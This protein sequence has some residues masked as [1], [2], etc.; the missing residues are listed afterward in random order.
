MLRRKS[1]D[2]YGGELPSKLRIARRDRPPY[3][4]GVRQPT[5]AKV[6]VVIVGGGP[7][8][9]MLA[10]FLDYH[11]I[12]CTILNDAPC[13]YE[14]PRGSTHN[15]RTME[16]YRRLG[17]ADTIRELGLPA[18]HPT[19]V[20]Y[21]TRYSA[22]ELARIPMPSADAKRQA[23]AHAPV[24]GQFPEPLHRANQMYVE[25][26]LFDRARSRPGIAVRYGWR[27]TGLRQD[28]DRVI[29]SAE[30]TRDG[31]TRSW[32]ARYAVG[33]DGG[34]S[35]VRAA[36]GARYS[37]SGPIDQE[38]L[39]R[40]A[41]AVYLRIPE[42]YPRYLA[43]RR[44]WGYWAV[45]HELIINLISLN[46]S[47]EFFLLTSS[48]DPDNADPEQVGD[49]VRRAVGSPVGVRVLDRRSWTPGLAL[50][51]DRFAD[52]RILLAGD[53]A[54]LFTPTGG[55]G[56]NT[57]VDDAA[58]LSWKIAARLAG[59]GGGELLPS[60]ELER[61]PIAERNTAAARTLNLNLGDINPTDV[62]EDGCREGQEQRARTGRLLG[63]YA[64]QFASVGVQLGARYD[65]SPVIARDGADPPPDS[66][67]AYTPSSVPGGRAPHAWIGD[68]RERGDSLYDRLGPGFTLLRLGP[69]PPDGGAFAAAT[70]AA[71]VP[72]AVLPVPDPAVRDLY[73]RDLALIRPDQH[74][75]WRGNRPPDD[76]GELLA[77]VTGGGRAVY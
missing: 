4:R 19:D 15:A 3:S 29:V 8:G 77:R 7:V 63:A 17:L 59:W 36:I 12:P 53:A 40:R 22:F 23:V 74:V 64:E 39:G 1:N 46:G 41:S 24:T 69:R 37:G 28:D 42:L 54:H 49:L 30:H 9:L 52:R 65:R 48:V 38:V 47:D 72:L 43:R 33:C 26:V 73:E 45:N 35:V 13:P 50:V 57:G 5:P 44:A 66:P 34:R 11:G 6:P 16:H 27:V 2:G 62:L 55:F 58:N 60:Y 21:F 18:D 68:G 76:P 10:L 32:Q 31:T 75:A 70:A 71:G 51:A 61:R 20:A 14:L 25:R 56:M 67:V